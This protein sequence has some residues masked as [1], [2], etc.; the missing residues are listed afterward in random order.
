MR[1]LGISFIPMLISVFC[2]CI[3]RVAWLYAVF[4]I[5]RFHDLGTIFLSYPISWILSLIMHLA[6]FRYYRKRLLR[7]PGTDTP[8]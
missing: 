1:G 5:P 6:A 8:A 4:S 2:I 3:F 7:P